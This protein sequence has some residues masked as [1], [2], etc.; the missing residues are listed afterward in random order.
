[1]IEPYDTMR[2]DFLTIDSESDAKLCIDNYGTAL[3][4]RFLPKKYLYLLGKSGFNKMLSDN[5]KLR[6]KLN[7]IQK[8]C[9]KRGELLELHELWGEVLNEVK[10]DLKC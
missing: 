4:L 3:S 8:L 2:D 5:K 10:E 7:E 6:A 1:M 9:D